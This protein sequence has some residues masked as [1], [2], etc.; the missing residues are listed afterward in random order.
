MDRERTTDQENAFGAVVEGDATLAMLG[1]AASR[2]GGSLQ[3]LVADTAGLAAGLRAAPVHAGG[4]LGQ[5]PA[6]VREPLLFRY[7]EGAVFAARLFA[8]GGWAGVDGAHRTQPATTLAI[9]E[10]G[11]YLKREEPRPL[12]PP[13]LAFV[14]EHRCQIADRDVLGSLELGAALAN[15]DLAARALSRAWRGDLYAVLE[16]GAGDA[17]IWF[18]LLSEPAAARKLRSAFARLDAHQA[19][20]R[21]TLVQGAYL[22]VARNLDAALLRELEPRFR[23]WAGGP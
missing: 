19:S 9:S 18:L 5:A 8:Q 3:A 7:R 21:F 17:S 14:S 2:Q 12:D 23:S 6:I 4:R 13:E 15:D 22:L 16:C 1:Y 20:K 11:L 10:P